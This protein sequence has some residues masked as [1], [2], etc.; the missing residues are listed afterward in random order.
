[1]MVSKKRGRR[2]VNEN[3]ERGQNVDQ[4]FI[5]SENVDDNF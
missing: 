2:D 1:M 4:N 3:L 5:Q